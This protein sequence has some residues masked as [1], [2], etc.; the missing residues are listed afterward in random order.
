[1]YVFNNIFIVLTFFS[2]QFHLK[3]KNILMKEE[4][5]KENKGIIQ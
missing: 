3:K 4:K 5:N 1:M 2:S